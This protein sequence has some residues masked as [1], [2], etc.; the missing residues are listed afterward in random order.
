MTHTREMSELEGD[1]KPAVASA[2]RCPKCRGV[3][4]VCESWTSSC[5]GYKDYKYT[6]KTCN[7]H[8]WVDG[9]DA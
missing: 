3:D 4:T 2:A 7:H 5:G 1:F 8:W 9:P 6:C